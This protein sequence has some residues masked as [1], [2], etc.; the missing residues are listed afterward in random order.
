MGLDS[1][2]RNFGI[3]SLYL[4]GDSDG[5]VIIQG[6]AG[7]NS[8]ACF[9]DGATRIYNDGAEK[10]A[11]TSTGIDV[12]G[13]VTADGLDVQGNVFINNGYAY[14]I[15]GDSGGS[16]IVGK[17]HNSSGVFTMA[18]LG[19]RNIKLTTSDADRLKVD[20]NGDISFYEATGTTPKFFWDASAE[21]LGIGTS[22]PKESAGLHIQ[23]SNGSSGANVNVAA[24][25]VFIDNNANTGIT[26]GS[27]ATGVGTYAFADST[28]ALRGAIQYDHSDDSMNFRV[29]SADRMRIDSSGRVGIGTASPSAGLDVAY[30]DAGTVAAEF[31]NASGFGISITPQVGGS[32]S[33]TQIGLASG[34]SLSFA[35]NNAE[36]MRIDSSGNLLVGTTDT[37]PYDRT[38][39][40]AIAMGDGLISSAQ[41]GGNAAIF[42][43]M[44]SVG[45]IIGLNYNGSAIGSIGV[46]GSRPYFG[47]SIN[48]SIKCDD[49]NNGS[50][51]PSNQSGVPNNNVS[52]IGLASNRW[53]DLYLGGGVYLGGTGSANKLDDYEEGSFAPVYAISGG[54]VT[55]GTNAGRY[56]KVG[57]FVFF[58]FRIRTTAVSGTGVLSMTLPFATAS[59]NR[60]GGSKGYARDWGVDMPEFSIYTPPNSSVV[61]FY[62]HAMNASTAQSVTGSQMGTGSD[63]NVLEGSIVYK[64]A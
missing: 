34:E 16:S 47:N 19:N 17:L 29:S 2:V 14:Q 37:S 52:D 44:T 48:F 35:P 3:G 30:G 53:N 56:V 55:T 64:S 9:A 63:D 50:L 41:S 59:E 18:S 31:K 1:W 43:R 42:N 49:A 40:N 6:K 11:T 8:V 13:T 4:A 51:V 38:S 24:N 32:G 46:Q 25:E 45:S 58:T 7:E 39:G 5:D 33:V 15:G 36:A 27:S 60:S 61:L 22:S 10:L 62:R 54:S 21:S 23:G 20:A 57:S 26:L 28:V 12:T